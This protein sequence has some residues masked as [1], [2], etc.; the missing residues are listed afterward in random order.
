M[1]ND[2]KKQKVNLKENKQLIKNALIDEN[3]FNNN[4]ISYF[5]INGKEGRIILA[6][7]FQEL[8]KSELFYHAAFFYQFI[9]NSE[10]E[11]TESQSFLDN[12]EFRYIYFPLADSNEA[13]SLYSVLLIKKDYNIFSSLDIIKLIQ[14]MIFEII[15]KN[16][17]E[18][19][20]SIDNE[21]GKVRLTLFF[22]RLK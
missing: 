2:E 1:N 19:K 17:K 3:K 16:P 12:K 9:K 8:T 14:R 13:E 10:K 18:T 15:K 7:Q 5:I 4:L 22:Y 21:K 11:K 20:N 6:R